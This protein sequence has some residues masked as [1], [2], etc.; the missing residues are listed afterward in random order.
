MSFES[1]IQDCGWIL[2]GGVIGFLA[3]Y[4]VVLCLPVCIGLLVPVLMSAC[5]R[6]EPGVGSIMPEWISPM[7]STADRGMKG[8]LIVGLGIGCFGFVIG[9]VV[10]FIIIV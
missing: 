7:Q 2:F 8:V 5:S 4:L 1:F 6:R 9:C 10:A 3:S